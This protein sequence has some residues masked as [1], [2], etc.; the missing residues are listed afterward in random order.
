MT[1]FVKFAE[2]TLTTLRWLKQQGQKHLKMLEYRLK[3]C[4]KLV[5]D[6]CMADS[7]CGQC[8]VYQLGMTGIPVYNVNNNCATG[9]TALVMGK[10][11]IQGDCVY[12]HGFPETIGKSGQFA[13]ASASSEGDFKS[14]VIFKEIKENLGK[15]GPMFVKK[16]KGVFCFK[17][18]GKN[19]TG[20]WVVDAKN[21]SGSVKF[22]GDAKGDVT[23]I[24]EDEDMFNL[25]LGK[26]SP[27]QAFFQGKLKIQGNMGLAM[28]LKE[29]ESRAGKSKL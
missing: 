29:F 28:K 5:W 25:M 8:A 11:L 12:R 1:K 7:T 4:S 3:K 26:L 20:V 14:A 6:M 2:K 13:P 15:D 17:V 21:G 23:I 9:S 19:R 16:M 27:Q 10:Q 24:M 18:K 22:G